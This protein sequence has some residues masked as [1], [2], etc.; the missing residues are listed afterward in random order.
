MV[1]SLLVYTNVKF[2]CNGVKKKQALTK[3]EKLKG[4]GAE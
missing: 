4:G 1:K 2:F 3:A